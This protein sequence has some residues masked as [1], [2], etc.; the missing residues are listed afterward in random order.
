MRISAWRTFSNL[1]VITSNYTFTTKVFTGS[2]ENPRKGRS[3]VDKFTNSAISLD[4][5]GADITEAANRQTLSLLHR[6]H[7]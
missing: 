5:R 1:A 4:Q 3:Q 7:L 2:S 6:C